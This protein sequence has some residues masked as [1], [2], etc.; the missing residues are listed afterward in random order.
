MN[1][2]DFLGSFTVTCQWC[3]PKA[4]F[5]KMLPCG[6]GRIILNILQRWMSYQ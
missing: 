2:P 5:S 6:T 3:W 4:N 1:I